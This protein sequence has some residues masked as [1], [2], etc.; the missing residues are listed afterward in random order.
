MID[1][2]HILVLC[3]QEFLRGQ[4]D[5]LLAPAPRPR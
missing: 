2:S 5:P 4:L 3:Q 1:L